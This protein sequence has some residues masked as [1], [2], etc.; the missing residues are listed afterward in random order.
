MLISCEAILLNIPVILLTYAFIRYR[1]SS[2]H[3]V[4]I[5]STSRVPLPITILGPLSSTPVYASS[6]STPSTNTVSFQGDPSDVLPQQDINKRIPWWNR[7]DMSISD[8]PE[9]S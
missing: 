2:L 4:R 1:C 7:P 9:C 6:I 5:K 3:S 8:L